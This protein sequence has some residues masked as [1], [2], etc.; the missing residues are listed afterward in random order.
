[1][2]IVYEAY[3]ALTFLRLGAV[4]ADA[5]AT[6]CEPMGMRVSDRRSDGVG[7]LFHRHACQVVVGI[8]VRHHS[9]QASVKLIYLSQ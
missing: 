5:V 1:M 6:V 3:A 7:G 4:V 9:A 8:Q 2:Q